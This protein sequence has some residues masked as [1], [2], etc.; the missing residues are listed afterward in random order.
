[1]PQNIY[2]QQKHVINLVK[3][4]EVN[5][6]TLIEMYRSIKTFYEEYSK[7]YQNHRI[8]SSHN[9]PMQIPP[10]QIHVI[11]AMSSLPKNNH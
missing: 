3:F 8:K 10:F 2:C 1:M 7:K 9:N 5:Y 4:Q 6:F 11:N